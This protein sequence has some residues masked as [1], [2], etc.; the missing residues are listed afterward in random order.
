MEDNKL[1]FDPETEDSLSQR[2]EILRLMIILCDIKSPSY[3][4]SLFVPFCTNDHYSLSKFLTYY[5][6]P[7]LAI[8]GK[9]GGVSLTS[10]PVSVLSG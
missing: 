8:Y 9:L 3:V 10:V 4:V 1:D 6:L 5:S 2:K 7:P